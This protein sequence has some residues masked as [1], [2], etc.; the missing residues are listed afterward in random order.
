[1]WGQ[2]VGFCMDD[3][4][5][6]DGF[7]DLTANHFYNNYLH[8]NFLEDIGNAQFIQ[9]V[10]NDPIGNQ[11]QFFLNSSTNG[12]WV[13]LIMPNI[14]NNESL[15]YNWTSESYGNQY[16]EDWYYRREMFSN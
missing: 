7:N 8:A 1:M 10:E 2:D 16:N 14:L 12:Y 9:G 13:D 4:S 15:I 6:L 3:N 5:T 11:S